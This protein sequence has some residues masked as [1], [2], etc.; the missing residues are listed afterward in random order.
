MIGKHAF[1]NAAI[2]VVTVLGLQIGVLLGGAVIIEQIFA[3]PGLGTY[4]GRHREAGRADD[5]GRI[6]LL[7]IMVVLANLTVDLTYG[8]LNPKVRVP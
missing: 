8:Y 6:V 4:G 7:A 1:K 3:M 2:P 5:P